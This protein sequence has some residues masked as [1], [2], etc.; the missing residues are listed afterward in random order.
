[1]F[2]SYLFFLLNLRTLIFS[3]FAVP[4]FSAVTVTPESNGVPTDTVDPSSANTANTSKSLYSA[5]SVPRLSTTNFVPSVTIYW[6]HWHWITAYM[7]CTIYYKLNDLD[8]LPQLSKHSIL[9]LSLLV[10]TWHESSHS[11]ISSRTWESILNKLSIP[12]ST[13]MLLLLCSIKR[14]R[15]P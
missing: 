9:R 14:T 2:L 4:L 11:L 5:A 12:L 1:M 7:M 8:D 3:P 13:V 10:C 6:C 15:R